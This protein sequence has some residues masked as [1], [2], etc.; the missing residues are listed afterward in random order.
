M[1]KQYIGGTVRYIRQG[2]VRDVSVES[3]ALDNFTLC[4]ECNRYIPRREY[5]QHCKEKHG[6]ESENQK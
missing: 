5:D 6:E 3:T 4:K 1:S 2:P